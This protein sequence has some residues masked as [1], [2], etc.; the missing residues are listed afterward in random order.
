[1]DVEMTKITADRVELD[2]GPSM[3]DIIEAEKAAAR[4]SGTI[5]GALPPVPPNIG[6]EMR[7]QERMAGKSLRKR[8][9]KTPSEPPE[10]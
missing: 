9:K 3:K 4:N 6:G 1:L 8:T 5:P 2:R 7:G 10:R